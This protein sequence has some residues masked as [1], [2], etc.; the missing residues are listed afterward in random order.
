MPGSSPFSYAVYRLVP[1][2]ERGERINVGVVVF[3]RPLDF[4]AARTS[5]DEERVARS[6]PTSIRTTVRPHL[7]ALERIAAGDAGAGPIAAARH[8]RPLPLA[9]VAVE[10]D[11]P[12]LG[13]AHG[14]VRPAGGGARQALPLARPAPGCVNDVVHEKR[15]A[16]DLLWGFLTAAFAVAL[17]RGHMGAGSDRS[18]LVI[19]VL[20]GGLVVLLVTAW[21]WTRRHPARIEVSYDLIALRHR[22]LPKIDRAAPRLRRALLQAL[23]RPRPLPHPARHGVAGGDQPPDVRPE[24]GRARLPRAPLALRRRSVREFRAVR[25][26]QS[27]GVHH[28]TLT[29]ADRQTSIDFW[30]GVLGMPFVF[31]QPNLD[32]EAESHLYFDPG[33]GRLITVFTHEERRRDPDA[34]GGATRRSR[35]SSTTSRSRSRRRRSPRRSSAWSSEASATAASRTAASWTRSTSPTRSAC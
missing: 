24:R 9:R 13:R 29:G 18:R 14:P 30:E 11:H 6:G 27:Q 16:N 32:N 34:R 4:L 10:H 35:A 3:S 21:V 25:K 23:G 12:A 2:V 17:V 19:D 33:D 20:V 28:I 7:S 22:D 1:R 8:D 26:L 15:R 5:L 31:E